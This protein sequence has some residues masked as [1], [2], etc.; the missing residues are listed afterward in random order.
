MIWTQS[1][2]CSAVEKAGSQTSI[3]SGMA[4]SWYVPVP[5]LHLRN[6]TADESKHAIKSGSLGVVAGFVDSDADI[7]ESITHLRQRF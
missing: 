2:S 5:I 3:V 1:G 7:D 6:P 4:L